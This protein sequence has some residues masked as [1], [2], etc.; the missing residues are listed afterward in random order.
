MKKPYFIG[1]ILLF[2]LVI[3]G[4]KLSSKTNLVL[5]RN[6]LSSNSIAAQQANVGIEK[7]QTP[8]DFSITTINGKQLRLSQFKQENKPVLLYFWAT[9]CPFCRKDF[10]V[11][12]NVYP[13]Y[14]DKVKILAID[15][16]TSEDDEIIQSYK[17]KMG[18]D[19][20]DF[21]AGSANI[22]SDYEITHTTTKYAVSK[23]GIILYKGSGAF[24]EQ[25]WEVLLNAL[26]SS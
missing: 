10:S 15:L 2:I 18:L 5:D 14:S 25:Q 12:K 26:A 17:N 9:W 3:N 23:D 16:D 1:L 19:G 4:C 20:I 6:D 8:P 24:N 21:A 11:L 22:L 7:G 13:K